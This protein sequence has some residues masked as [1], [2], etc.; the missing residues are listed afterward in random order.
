M[1]NRHRRVKKLQLQEC[2]RILVWGWE[3]AKLRSTCKVCGYE[4]LKPD[5]NYCVICGTKIERS[6]SK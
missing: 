5:F 3:Q 1:N 6:T 4:D 2:N